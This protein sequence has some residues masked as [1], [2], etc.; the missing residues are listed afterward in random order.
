[1]NNIE[2]RIPNGEDYI[3]FGYMDIDE[4]LG[5]LIPNIPFRRSI[6]Q[7]LYIRLVAFNEVRYQDFMLLVLKQDREK[8][9]IKHYLLY[10]SSL[11]TWEVDHILLQE[12]QGDEEDFNKLVAKKL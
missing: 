12:Y 6:G 3:T 10:S 8:K 7:D 9:E 5:R 2:V 4:D 11:D 1:M